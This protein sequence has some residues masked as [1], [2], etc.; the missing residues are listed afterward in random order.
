MVIQDLLYGHGMREA[1][2][3][4]WLLLQRGAASI[5]RGVTIIMQRL[6]ERQELRDLD[7]RMRR[8][9]GIG[10]C[11]ALALAQKPLWQA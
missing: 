11:E 7:W 9:V 4:S 1:V 5:R 3:L 6:A 8:D 10:R 2:Q